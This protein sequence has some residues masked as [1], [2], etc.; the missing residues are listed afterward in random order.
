MPPPEATE[1]DLNKPP[2]VVAPKR[3]LPVVPKMPFEAPELAPDTVSAL[4]PKMLV[5]LD[6]APNNKEALAEADV[7]R[8]NPDAAAALSLL[9]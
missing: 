8:D 4:D 9:G 3:L 1:E 7:K 2:P 5:E 6:D